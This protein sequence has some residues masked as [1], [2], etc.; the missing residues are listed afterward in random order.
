MVLRTI[1]LSWLRYVSGRMK[2]FVSHRVAEIQNLTRISDWHHVPTADN[3]ADIISRG[4][5]PRLMRTFGGMDRHF[6]NKMSPL[7]PVNR[8]LWGILNYLR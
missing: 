8:P 4:I 1:V 7:G 5:M 3:P 2:S 6:C